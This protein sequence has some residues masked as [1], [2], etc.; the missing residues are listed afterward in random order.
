M[1]WDFS[2]QL[3]PGASGSIQFGVVVDP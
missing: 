2:G 1:R 3:Q